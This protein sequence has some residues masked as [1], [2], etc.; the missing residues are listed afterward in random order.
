MYIAGL[1]GAAALVAC[2]IFVE[3]TYPPS[4]LVGKASELRRKTKNWGIHAKQEEVELDLRELL[5]KN[6]SRYVQSS[7]SLRDQGEYCRSFYKDTC[8]NSW[9]RTQDA[10]KTSIPT[11]AKILRHSP[12]TSLTFSLS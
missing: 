11:Q 7:K 5:E 2:F 12:G 3:E 4:I 10:T 1:M 6:V 8:S 9:T